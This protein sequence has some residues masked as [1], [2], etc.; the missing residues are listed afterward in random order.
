MRPP[1][2]RLFSYEAFLDE[3]RALRRLEAE[4]PREGCPEPEEEPLP[5][6]GEPESELE[7]ADL[8]EL[9]P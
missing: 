3:R 7:P 6:R 5:Q 8:L 2:R 9:A 4:R 1:T